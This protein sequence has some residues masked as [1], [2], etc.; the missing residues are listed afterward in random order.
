M[1]VDL[2][3]RALYVTSAIFQ[4]EIAFYHMSIF[5]LATILENR[6]QLHLFVTSSPKWQRSNTN[7]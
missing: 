1:T 6:L 4:G 7:S 5:K 3:L 2:Y